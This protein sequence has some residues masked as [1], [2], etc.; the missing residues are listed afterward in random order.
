MSTTRRRF[1]LLVATSLTLP[2][3]PAL[4]A[5][6]RAKPE[7]AK[8]LLA[9][10]VAHVKAVGKDKAMADFMVKP[11]PWI[12]R[13]LYITVF[14][15]NGKTLAHGSIPKL[16]GKDNINM[17]DANGKFHVKE[18]LEIAKAKGKGQQEFA[19]LNPMTKQ[20]E[21]KLMFFERLDDIVIACGA[22][23]PA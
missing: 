13:D 2:V 6:D 23:K 1:A 22:Y 16:V 20:I 21:P 15:L 18:R 17:Q 9:K 7:E 3:L 5:D 11:G 19:F 8:A 12:E 14:D 10:A 4:A